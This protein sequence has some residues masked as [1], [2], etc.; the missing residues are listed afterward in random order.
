MVAEQQTRVM[1][2]RLRAAGFVED[3]KTG[4]HTTWKAA[5]GTSVSVPDGHR[6][7]SPGLVRKIE[8]AIEDAKK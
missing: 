2:K 8:K 3:R 5:N 7:Q 6:K 4:S 1:V